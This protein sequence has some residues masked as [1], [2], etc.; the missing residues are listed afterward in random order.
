MYREYTYSILYLWAVYEVS[1]NVKLII[2]ARFHTLDLERGYD[3]DRADKRLNVTTCLQGRKET[4]AA[5][6]H[7][8]FQNSSGVVGSI[9]RWESS[10]RPRMTG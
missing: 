2:E 9:N 10:P 8:H 6:A 1:T 3:P 5:A 7:V 4:D